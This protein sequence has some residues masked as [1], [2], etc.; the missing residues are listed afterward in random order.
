LRFLRELL[1]SENTPKLLIHG[2]LH[3]QKEVNL[4]KTKIVQV[5]PVRIMEI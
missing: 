3:E 4:A 2:H 5:F 1:D